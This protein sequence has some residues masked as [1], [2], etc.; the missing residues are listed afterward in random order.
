[1]ATTSPDGPGIRPFRARDGSFWAISE[2]A[3][4]DRTA[5]RDDGVP[6]RLLHFVGPRGEQFDVA[7][8]ERAPGLTDAAVHELIDAYR[9]EKVAAGRSRGR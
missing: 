3:F 4:G 5:G 9:R 1:M 2:R 8:C 7:T 6:V